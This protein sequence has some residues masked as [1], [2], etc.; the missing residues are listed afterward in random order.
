MAFSQAPYSEQINVHRL[1]EVE[2]REK[3]NFRPV[4]GYFDTTVDYSQG[5]LLHAI[6]LFSL[7]HH[8]VSVCL[9]TYLTKAKCQKKPFIVKHQINT[10][11]QF[12]KISSETIVFVLGPRPLKAA[13]LQIVIPTLPMSVCLCSLVCVCVC[14]CVYMCLKGPQLLYCIYRVPQRQ[15]V[16][17]G[18]NMM[19]YLSPPSGFNRLISNQLL[20]L[21][22]PLDLLC[23]LHKYCNYNMILIYIHKGNIIAT[24]NTPPP[25]SKAS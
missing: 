3:E 12:I 19:M 13:G 15:T 5:H 8:F 23:F 16:R 2:V 22:L 4:I 20:N 6:P 21:D 24:S 9:V 10:L 1:L 14:V 18:R 17:V 11:Q 25:F 7:P